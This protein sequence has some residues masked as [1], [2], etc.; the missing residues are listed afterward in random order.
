M[1]FD[2]LKDE[3]IIIEGY[4]KSDEYDGYYKDGLFHGNGIQFDQNHN[5]LNEGKWEQGNLITG[6][7]RNWLIMTTSGKLIFKPD[8]PE[9]PYDPTDDF[10]YVPLEQYGNKPFSGFKLSLSNIMDH[11]ISSFYVVDRKVDNNMEELTN[12]RTLT[13]F[14][15]EVNPESLKT[16]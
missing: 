12:I 4:G 10:Q 6:I 7:E 15:E 8:C 9:D 1:G 3:A 2:E 13:E 16:L 14:L 11:D 5:P